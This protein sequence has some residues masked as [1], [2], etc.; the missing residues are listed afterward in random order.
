MFEKQHTIKKI[1][2]I[3]GYGL[4]TGEKVNLNFCPAPINHG[5]KFKRIDL[6]DQ[7]IIEADVDYVTDLTRGTTLEK[8]GIKV[9]TVE[10]ALA[11]LVGLQIDNVLIEIDGS[12][13][14]I[15]DG[16]SIE[17]IKLLENSGLKEQ[18]AARNFF[19]LTEN[20]SYTD[21]E[22]HVEIG[23]LPLN[24]YRLTVM[25]D[26][27]SPVL[28]SQ[29]AYLNNITNFKRDIASCRTFCFLHEVQTLYESNLIQGGNFNNAIVIIDKIISEDKLQHLAKLFNIEQVKIQKEGILNNIKLHY[30]NEPARH[31]L[32]DLVGD[33][34]LIGRPIKGQ[35]LAARPGHRSNVAFAKKIKNLIKKEKKNKKS[36]FQYTPKIPAI[37][38][39]S[40]I[41]EMLP[42][43]SPFVMVDKVVHLEEYKIVGIKNVTM[44][45]PFFTGHFP[46][47]PIMP[48]V[49]QVEALA[50]TGALLIIHRLGNANYWT[51]FVS[52]EKC[53]FRRKVV[54][55]D[56]LVLV[57]HLLGDIRRSLAKMK[58][59]AY[60]GNELACE[61][62]ITASIVKK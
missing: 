42:H 12:E 57:S 49:L 61:L 30:K 27:N 39:T 37:M 48:G 18:N 9:S 53:R 32:L 15:L 25:V 29:H 55:G 26:Y 44:N 14:P 34:A 19:I 10:H 58:G 20:V 38:D 50:Q 17:Y 16:S 5:Y 3:S 23:G 2:K 56:T 45:E 36:I 54:P 46:G 11:A 21:E 40:K 41:L 62:Y 31:K 35:I 1:V 7:P 33:L 60:V 51:Y 43:A 59:E 28:G 52:I 6:K 4:H 13:I 47:N 8:N 24:D 22:N